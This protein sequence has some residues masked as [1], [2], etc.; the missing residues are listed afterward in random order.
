MRCSHFNHTVLL[1][2]DFIE[3]YEKIY[4]EHLKKF[5]QKTLIK[6]KLNTTFIHAMKINEFECCANIRLLYK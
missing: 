3:T 2:L 1:W 6:M 5:Y 4:A